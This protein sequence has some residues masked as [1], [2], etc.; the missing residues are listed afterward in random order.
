[1]SPGQE[2]Y[3]WSLW[4]AAC[5]QQ[6]WEQKDSD[7]RHA[8]HIQALGRDKSHKDFT[9]ADFDRVKAVLMVFKDPD[10]VSARMQLDAYEACD[11]EPRGLPF[12]K[13]DRAPEADD[14]GE[15][16]R[17][18][19]RIKQL[20]PEPYIEKVCAD[21]FQTRRWQD[22]PISSLTLLR[23]LLVNRARARKRREDLDR[24]T[25]TANVPAE[26]CPF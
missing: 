20:F 17:L 5:E 12:R 14:P 25:A 13:Y 18:V 2:R 6:G 19:Y 26:N 7:K 16:K 8:V 23:D 1:M 15:R 22:L 3:Y 21:Q 4:K 24:V 11:Q 9:N 10:N